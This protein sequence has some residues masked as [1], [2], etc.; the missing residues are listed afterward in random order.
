MNE[1]LMLVPEEAARRAANV[2]ESVADREK[3]PPQKQWLKELALMLRPTPEGKAIL[4]KEDET[5]QEMA[6][7]IVRGG[8]LSGPIQSHEQL[9]NRIVLGLAE[10]YGHARDEFEEELR[11]LKVENS[12]LRR[13]VADAAELSAEEEEEPWR[14]ATECLRH[15]CDVVATF[16]ARAD[17]GDAARA[18][19]TKAVLEL[20]KLMTMVFP[21]GAPDKQGRR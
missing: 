2:V 8:L 9:I 6:K 13:T 21:F 3:K 1:K 17:A 15:L 14:A 12:Q 10:R 19:M 18:N 20:E 16:A 11:S 4:I 5:N 7:R